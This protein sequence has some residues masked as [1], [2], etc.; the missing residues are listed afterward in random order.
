MPHRSPFLFI[1][2]YKIEQNQVF[3]KYLVTGK[4]NFLPGHFKDN[5]VFPASIM[6]EALGQLGVLFLVG[7]VENHEYFS[8]EVDAS[9][10]YFTSCDG[11]RCHRVVKPGDELEMF[12]KVK[13]VRRPLAI[14]EG[15]IQVAGEKTAR[16]ESISLL[17]DY[18]K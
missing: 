6:I 8:N 10:I 12:L 15:K 2:R 1:D 4:E 7:S 13:K 14:F 9:T 3:A 11:V 18:K 5:P 17:F 16:A